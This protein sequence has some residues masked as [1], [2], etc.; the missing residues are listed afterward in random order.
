MFNTNQTWFVSFA[1][2]KMLKFSGEL[3]L[4]SQSPRRQ[5]ILQK[6][7]LPFQTRVMDIDESF[8]ADMEPA[9]VPSFLANQKALAFGDLD[10]STVV[11]AAD[12]VVIAPD[13]QIMNKP[14]TEEEAFAMLSALSGQTHTV[15]TAFCIRTATSCQVVSDQARVTFR[16]L[17]ASEISYYIETCRP[18]D[19]AGSY[20]VQ[21]FIGLAGVVHL[22]GSFYTI[23]GL[24]AH[25]VYDSLQ[26]W[27]QW[28]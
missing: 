21:D 4:A 26:P 5:E 28:S 6:M 9:E 3:I 7:G 27:I 23:M 13:G 14:A 11:L 10:S 17:T 22:E 8:P 1:G 24:P 25:L 2:K 16:P 20:G 18:F 15:V 12:T 19:K